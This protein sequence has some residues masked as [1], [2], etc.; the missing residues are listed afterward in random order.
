M[1]TKRAQKCE[2][3]RP[4]GSGLFL[5]YYFYFNRLEIVNMPIIFEAKWMKGKGMDA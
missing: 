2:K 1:T 3:P 4:D 5:I